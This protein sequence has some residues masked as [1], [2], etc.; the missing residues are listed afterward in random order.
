[1]NASAS[2]LADNVAMP[3]SLKGRMMM[4]TLRAVLIVASVLLGGSDW[5][6]GAPPLRTLE[7]KV[8]GVSLDVTPPVLSVPKGIAGSISAKLSGGAIPPTGSFL[9]ATLRGPSFP[10]RRLVGDASKALFLPPLTLLGDS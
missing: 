7:Y 8:V 6:Q 10:A 9:E 4:R 5:L 2:V 3:I 1:M